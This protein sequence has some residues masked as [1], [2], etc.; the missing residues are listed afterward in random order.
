MGN[1]GVT[2]FSEGLS[3]A[4]FNSPQMDIANGTDPLLRSLSLDFAQAT[5]VYVV[6]TLR[7]LLTASLVGGGVDLIDLI[8]IDIK[9]ERDVGVGS[10]NQVRTALGLALSVV[11]GIDQRSATAGPVENRLRH[12]RSSRSVHWRTRESAC[13]QRGCRA[14]VSANHRRSVFGV[15]RWRSFLL[16][17][18]GLRSCHHKHVCEYDACRHHPA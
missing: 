3:Q 7:N 2:T 9:R 15:A 10:L 11:Q 12:H 6:P 1:T 8:A 13:A 14:D 17:Q 18:P 5:D 4:F 16:A